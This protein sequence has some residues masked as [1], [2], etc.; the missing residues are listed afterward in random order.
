M[1]HAHHGM[2]EAQMQSCIEECQRCATVCARTLHH[3]LEKGGKHAAAAHAIAL[4]DC[5]EICGTSASFL[6]RGSEQHAAVCRACAEICRAC[7]ASCRAMG[8]DEMM[9]QCAEACRR[10][11]E[12]CEKMAGVAA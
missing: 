4:V 10:C 8:D 11:A 12:S 7:E 6:A 1:P 3:C 2:S 9:R 5:A